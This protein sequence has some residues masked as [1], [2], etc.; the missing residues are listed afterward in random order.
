MDPTTFF[1]A[2]TRKIAALHMEEERDSRF[3]GRG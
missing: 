2:P 3:A 1:A